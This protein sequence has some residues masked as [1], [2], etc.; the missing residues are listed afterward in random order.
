MG[1]SDERYRFKSHYSGSFKSITALSY[2]SERQNF[3]TAAAKNGTF[4]FVV[5]VHNFLSYVF[6]FK[7]HIHLNL[8]IT[9]PI[10]DSLF[11]QTKAGFQSIP[12]DKKEIAF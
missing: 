5:L 12:P 3:F 11:I 9:Y 1:V 8:F 6:Y 7:C 2:L 4:A 10:N